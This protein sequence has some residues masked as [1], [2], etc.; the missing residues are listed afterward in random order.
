[1]IPTEAY[2]L[3]PSA[4]CLDN[5]AFHRRVALLLLLMLLISTSARSCLRA[6]YDDGYANTNFLPVVFNVDVVV[7]RAL[8]SVALRTPTTM[9]HSVFSV[10]CVCIARVDVDTASPP[11][12][13][14]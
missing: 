2:P 11:T 10:I 13:A 7:P 9:A 8:T 12:N 1:M 5:L 6:P 14:T 4:P 3:S